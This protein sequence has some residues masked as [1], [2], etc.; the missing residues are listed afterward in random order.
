MKSGQIVYS[1][2]GHDRRNVF[3]VV[4]T[5]ILKDGEYAFLVDGK[6]RPLAK[7][8]RKKYKHIQPTNT[9]LDIADFAR[10]TDSDV[11]KLLKP[12]S[13]DRNVQ[14]LVDNAVQ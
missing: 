13:V 9:I 8:K 3:I 7:P 5:E 1:K 4:K 12:F 14:S 11:R 6:S 10:L 2:A